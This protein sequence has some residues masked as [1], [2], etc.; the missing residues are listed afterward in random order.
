MQMFR[1]ISFA[2]L[3]IP[4]FAVWEE[5]VEVLNDGSTLKV[6]GIGIV[7]AEWLRERCTSTESVDPV[8]FQRLKSPHEYEPP[9]IA[10]A[11]LRRNDDDDTDQGELF[12]VFRDEHESSFDLDNLREHALD[13]DTKE[14]SSAFIQFPEASKPDLVLWDGTLVSPPIMSYVDVMESPFSEDRVRFYGL[15]QSTGFVVLRGAPLERKVV[16]AAAAE[17]S[18]LR[19]TNWGEEWDVRTKSDAETEE[20]RDLAYT[21]KPIGMHTDNPYRNPTPDFQLLHVIEQCECDE[22]GGAQEAPCEKCTVMNSFTDGFAAAQKLADESPELFDALATIPV[23]FENDGGDGTSALWYVSPIIELKPQY[24][25]RESMR[26]SG[27]ISTSEPCRGGKCIKAIRF[28]SKSGGYAPN[29]EPEELDV[30][31]RAKRRFSE[32]IHDESMHVKIQLRQGD[33]VVFDNQRLLHARSSIKPSDGNRLLQGCYSDRDGFQYKW[34]RARRHSRTP[35]HWHSLRT[36]S[37]RDFEVIGEEIGKMSIADNL[38][39]ML[40]SQKGIFWQM[41]V[42]LYEHGVQTATRAYRANESEDLVV[43]ALFHDISEHI[44]PGGHGKVSAGLLAPYI[45][46]SAQWVL[47]NHEVFQGYYYFHHFG[48]DRN[49]RDKLYTEETAEVW[50]LTRRW[51]E[52]YDQAAFDPFYPSLPLEFFKP[53][54]SRVLSRTPFW[55]DPEQYSVASSVPQE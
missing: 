9:L 30:F 41:P 36:A 15:L 6:D 46:Q 10:N 33:V 28:S 55:W 29:L 43:A 22:E 19:V 48:G 8:T 1:A 47:S 5:Q 23:R 7:H 3:V 40:E 45:D 38:Y 42:D 16:S 12:V 39:N 37:K 24:L 20:M 18:T 32:I 2:C 44:V 14:S 51:C 49:D 25:G 11:S 53:M 54:V 31:Y 17:L 34:E 13:D 27:S 52:D 50:E 35:T 26:W 4:S 21:P